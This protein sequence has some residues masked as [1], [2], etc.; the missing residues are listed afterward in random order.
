MDHQFDESY[1]FVYIKHVWVEELQSH[2]ENGEDTLWIS[3][4]L[5]LLLLSAKPKHLHAQKQLFQQLHRLHYHLLIFV[6]RTKTYPKWR[7]IVK[8]YSTENNKKAS[9][10][11]PFL[12]KSVWE[13]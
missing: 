13:T 5:S 6:W 7:V 9:A 1:P 8:K 11:S 12:Q 10:H 4:H 2:L 3:L